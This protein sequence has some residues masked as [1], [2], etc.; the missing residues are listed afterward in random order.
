VITLNFEATNII[1]GT[2]KATIVKFYI[3]S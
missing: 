2:V 3:K 1:S